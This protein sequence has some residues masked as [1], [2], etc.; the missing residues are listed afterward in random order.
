MSAHPHDHDHDDHDHHHDHDHD[1][2][3]AHDHD[4]SD[5]AVVTSEESPNRRRI[6]VTVPLARVQRAYERAYRDIAKNARIKGFRPGKVPRAVLE[7]MIGASLGEEIERTLVNE[8]LGA[9]LAKAGVEPVAT[10]AVDASPPRADSEFSYKALVEIRPP[11]ALPELELDVAPAAALER[12]SV[13][14]AD[15]VDRD[16]VPVRGGGAGGL[17][18]QRRGAQSQ[19]G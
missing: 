11:I 1:H 5:L 17:L 15:E 4:G 13:Y 19:L 9:A 7:R 3:H 16:D 18:D 6:E 2:G 8:T 12:H 10:P 14:A